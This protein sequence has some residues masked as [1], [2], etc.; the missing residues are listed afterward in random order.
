MTDDKMA[1]FALI[2][3]GGDEGFIRELLAYTADQIMALDREG[4]AGAA[5]N[6]K[7]PRR[8]AKRSGYRERP[9]HTR[10]G[11]IDLKIRFCAR[12]VMCCLSWTHGGRRRRR[13][14]P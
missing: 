7:R 10:V 1:L 5:L 12:G 8:L 11:T 14:W 4:A 9:W 6:A 3:K 2:E 13:A